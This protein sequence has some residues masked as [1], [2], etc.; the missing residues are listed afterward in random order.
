[1]Q[2]AGGIDDQRLDQAAT[3]SFQRRHA[4][5]LRDPR[6]RSWG[7]SRRRPPSA[8]RSSC[9]MAAGR[10]TSVLTSMTRRRCVSLSQRASLPAVV[11][12]PAPCRPASSTTCGGCTLSAKPA[13]VLAEQHYQLP[14]QDADERLSRRQ[15]GGHFGAECAHLDAVDEALD[16]RQ[17][18]I[19]LEQRHAHF[20]QRLGDVLFG[21]TAAAAQGLNG[22]GQA[23]GQLVEHGAA[24][25]RRA[26][27]YSLWMTDYKDRRGQC[28]DERSGHDSARAAARHR[29]LLRHRGG[30]AVGQSLPHPPSRRPRRTARSAAGTPAG[31]AGSLARRQSGHPGAGERR[32]HHRGDAARAA[33]RRPRALPRS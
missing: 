11:V 15:A 19:R 28:A 10:R 13:G 4:Q 8:S 24:L 16:D 12:L 9:R 6:W 1:M 2:T 32:G 22:A 33:H 30:D 7:R 25:R 14:M 3:R 27:L 20:A 31:A 21:D 23:L 5:W 17:R 26:A 29:L 18:D